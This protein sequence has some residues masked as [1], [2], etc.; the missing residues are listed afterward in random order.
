LA[1]SDLLQ[2]TVADLF[3]EVASETPAPGGGAVAAVAVAL[4]ASL[5]EMVARFSRRSW[6]GAESALEAAQ[7]QRARVAPLAQA[8]AEAYAQFLAARGRPGEEAAAH[9]RTVEVPLEV[10]ASGAEV[11]ALAT[12]L[13]EQGNPNLRGDAVAAALA[14]SAGAQAAAKLVE[15]NVEGRA[16]E[17]LD[18]ARELAAAAARAAERALR[19]SGARNP[20]AGG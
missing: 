18:R 1:S 13:A 16:D 6:E 7:A 19:L 3:E 20:R 9:A 10:A 8:D 17:R 5:V 12:A 14:A 4:G 11:A 15:I 2:K